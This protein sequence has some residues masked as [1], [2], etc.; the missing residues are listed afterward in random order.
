[1]LI[2]STN[3]DTNYAKFDKIIKQYAKKNEH[4]HITPT[5]K[6]EIYLSC[7]KFGR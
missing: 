6:H 7:L 3:A 5:L 4:F 2:S 1:M